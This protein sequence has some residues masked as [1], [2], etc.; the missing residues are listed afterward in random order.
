MKRGNKETDY[1]RLPIL[2]CLYI[3]VLFYLYANV[4]V[5]HCRLY[6]NETTAVGLLFR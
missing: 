4:F 6:I 3:A 5:I 2:S 1:Y